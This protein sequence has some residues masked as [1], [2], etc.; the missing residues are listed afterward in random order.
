MASP[1]IVVCMP[2][3]A[4]R[5]VSLYW[6]L[7][8]RFLPLPQVTK[9]LIRSDYRVDANREALAE[10]ALALPGITHLLWWDDD[11]WPPTGA[12]AAL[13]RW[14]YPAVAG[15]YRDKQGRSTVLRFADAA[16]TRVARLEP[17]GPAQH[18]WADA[19]GLGWCLLDVRLLRRLPRPWFRFEG[20]IGEDCY[21]F[22]QL[23]RTWHLPVLVDGEAACGHEMP[24][25]LQAS[26]SVT[27]IWEGL[28][29]VVEAAPS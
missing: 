15:P 29:A 19:A 23:Q 3:T 12:L 2:T 1:R 8:L 10:A 11:I 21:F 27:P 6:A 20:P 25:R 7:H 9:I 26:G 4:S 5:A 13:L 22:A 17:P 28:G 16:L 14:S 24:T 18:L